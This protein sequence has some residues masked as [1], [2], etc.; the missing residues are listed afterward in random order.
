MK[1]HVTIKVYDDFNYKLNE[2]QFN[3]EDNDI[4]K[5]TIEDFS[6]FSNFKFLRDLRYKKTIYLLYNFDIN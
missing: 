4:K 1:S 2:L 6:R 5:I 3:I